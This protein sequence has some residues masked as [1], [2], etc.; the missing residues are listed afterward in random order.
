MFLPRG[1]VIENRSVFRQI[2]E[3]VSL[4]LWFWWY[5]SHLRT[6]RCCFKG[7]GY[8]R[9]LSVMGRYSKDT[10]LFTAFPRGDAVHKV[11]GV[12]YL[13]YF[14]TSVQKGAVLEGQREGGLFTALR[15]R[16]CFKIL[17]QKNLVLPNGNTAVCI[18]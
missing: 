8:L 4:V 9:Q 11:R 7:S 13:R 5:L 10:L 17:C 3:G 6:R 15:K 16:E 18:V 1:D 12:V 2:H 14:G